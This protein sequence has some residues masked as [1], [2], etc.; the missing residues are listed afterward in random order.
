MRPTLNILSDELIVKILDEAKRIM[1][2]TGMEIRGEN[3][4]QRLLDHGLKLD[5][6]GKR[7]LFPADIVDDAWR[8]FDTND[9]Q[10]LEPLVCQ[11]PHITG[12]VFRYFARGLT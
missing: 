3:L 6:T 12:L 4:R 7:V 2:E 11:R 8:E 10:D 5:K 9:C 1:S